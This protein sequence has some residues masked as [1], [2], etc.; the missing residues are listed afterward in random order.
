[1][2]NEK[3][4]QNKCKNTHTHTH[5]QVNKAKKPLGFMHFVVSLDGGAALNPELNYL[6]VYM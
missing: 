6:Q 4:V 3:Q 2:Q 1:M 5:T